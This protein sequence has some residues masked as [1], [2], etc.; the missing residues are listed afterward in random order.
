MGPLGHIS[1]STYTNAPMSL[2]RT[3]RQIERG[4]T[5]EVFLCLQLS[6]SC[7][8]FQD[9]RDATIADGDFCLVDTARSYTFRYPSDRSSQLVLKIPRS[10]MA[11]RIANLAALTAVTVRNTMPLGGLASGFIQML[12]GRQHGLSGMEA[13][14]IANQA[15]DL[16]A[17]ALSERANLEGVNVSSVASIALLR[18]RQVVEARIS[19]PSA[20]CAEVAASASMSVRNANRLLAKEGTSLERYILRRRL[21][22]CRDDLLDPAQDSRST[23]EIAYS[24]GFMDAAH[25]S[26][27]FKAAFGTPPSEF[28]KARQQP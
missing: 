1:L 27:S 23:S 15:V 25:F 28:R 11:A 24:W 6:G 17:L 20:R 18:L 7:H 14:Q 22:K 13:T 5:E 2:W 26:R 9:G 21:E 4:P 3:A 16:A 10:H 12:P 19:D 8:V